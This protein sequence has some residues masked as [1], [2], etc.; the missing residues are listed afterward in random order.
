MIDAKD[1][2]NGCR[3]NG[4]LASGTVEVLKAIPHGRVPHSGEVWF[5]PTS[6]DCLH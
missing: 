5:N 2:V 1:I 6:R 3:L 4:I